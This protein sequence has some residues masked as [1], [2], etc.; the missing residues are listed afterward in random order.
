M[1]Q[2]TKKPQPSPGWFEKA[3][4]RMQEMADNG[5]DPMEWMK[6]SMV[7]PQLIAEGRGSG[8]SSEFRSVSSGLG[9]GGVDE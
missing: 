4:A 2:Q 9:D 8:P 1:T 6:T 7:C 3:L 5:E